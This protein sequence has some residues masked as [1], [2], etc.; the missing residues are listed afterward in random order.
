MHLTLLSCH[1]S[2][3]ELYKAATNE[4]VYT[5]TSSLTWLA[6][7]ANQHEMGNAFLGQRDHSQH[8]TDLPT[9]ATVCVEDEAKLRESSATFDPITS[10]KV[11]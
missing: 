2:D 6:K 4:D 5:F 3:R 7:N 9:G 10:A 11:G 1:T 8:H